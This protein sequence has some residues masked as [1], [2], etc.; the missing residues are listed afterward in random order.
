M[1]QALD[2]ELHVVCAYEKFEMD[3]VE[4]DGREYVFSTEEAAQGLAEEKTLRTLRK[5]Y[6]DL[7][8]LA[9]AS[10]G[11]PAESL[12]RSAEDATAKMIVVGNK[13]VQGV[14]ASSAA[15]RARLP[16]RRTATCTSPTP[17]AG[18]DDRRQTR[19]EERGSGRQAANASSSLYSLA[20]VARSSSE[21]SK[22]VPYSLTTGGVS[23]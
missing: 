11:K 4:S 3:A 7:R 5:R 21:S 10:R 16:R 12:L 17:T 18:I 14:G 22:A 20:A 23:N 19:S 2:G 1:A 9:T 13:R 8:G 15:S 6:P